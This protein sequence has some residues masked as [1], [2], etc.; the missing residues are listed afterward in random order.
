MSA[1][2]DQAQLRSSNHLEMTSKNVH[3]GPEAPIEIIFFFLY[4][5]LYL[6]MRFQILNFVLTTNTKNGIKR[7]VISFLEG[8]RIFLQSS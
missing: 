8:F 7:Q 5:S 3:R 4:F 6:A 1:I 2:Q